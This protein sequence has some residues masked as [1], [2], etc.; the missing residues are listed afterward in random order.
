LSTFV[1][2]HGAWHGAWCWQRV[3]PLLRDRGH[4]VAAPTLTGL[5]ERSH[6]L[7]RDV[8]LA[9]H[10]QDVVDAVLAEDEPVV[11]VGHSY[12]GLVVREAADLVRDQIQRVVLVEG[13]AGP[14]GTSMF[15]LAPEWFAD[16][17][18]QMAE[19]SGE[20]WR[21]PAPAAAT[22]GV[23]DPEDASWLESRL[24]EH[25]LQTFSDCTSLTDRAAEIPLGAIVAEAG[26]LPFAE[27]ARALG[28][29]P[30]ALAGGHDLMVTSPA[31]LADALLAGAP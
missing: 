13:W 8:G 27:W 9:T 30:Q 17:I 1:L 14:D 5:G 24:T 29:E 7:T 10:V 11:L 20:G 3:E 28:A 23:S 2:V 18:R 22:V 19:Q 4:T 12:A 31:P 16:G 25:P 26:M 15:G 21:I 6:E